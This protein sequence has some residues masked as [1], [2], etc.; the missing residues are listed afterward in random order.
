M[1]YHKCKVRFNILRV[2]Q[3]I[4]IRDK[5]DTNKLMSHRKKNEIYCETNF[6]LKKHLF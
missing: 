5:V 1:F 4:L 6:K 3:T 2:V